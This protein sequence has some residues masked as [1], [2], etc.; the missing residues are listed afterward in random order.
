MKNDGIVQLATKGVTNTVDNVVLQRIIRMVE[1]AKIKNEEV[2]LFTLNYCTP[3]GRQRIFLEDREDVKETEVCMF[4]CKPVDTTVIVFQ[5]ERA[6]GEI[7][8]LYGLVS[9]G[10]ELIQKQ[11]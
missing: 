9:E 10:E 5:Y 4:C 6:N 7:T 11:Q 8:Q 2:L 1:D 3:C